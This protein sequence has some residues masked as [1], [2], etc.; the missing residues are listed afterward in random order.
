MNVDGLQF[1]EALEGTTRSEAIDLVIQT[2]RRTVTYGGLFFLVQ[3]LEVSSIPKLIEQLILVTC[4]FCMCYLGSR[5][6]S[7]LEEIQGMHIWHQSA[8]C[9]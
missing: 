5:P 2:C 9:H 8:R 1:Y 7:V 3:E 4:I 6:V